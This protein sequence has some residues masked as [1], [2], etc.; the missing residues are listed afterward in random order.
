MASFGALERLQKFDW[1]IQR[2]HSLRTPIQNDKG[3][4]EL[5]KLQALQLLHKPDL[6]FQAN[7]H[8][9]EDGED[10]SNEIVD[11][12]IYEEDLEDEEMVEEDTGVDKDDSDENGKDQRSEDFTRFGERENQ[13]FI[14]DQQA[15]PKPASYFPFSHNRYDYHTHNNHQHGGKN[16]QNNGIN[17]FSTGL[18]PPLPFKEILPLLENSANK[19]RSLF[20]FISQKLFIYNFLSVIKY[21][22]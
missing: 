5:R 14:N 10:P 3:L 21:C 18:F 12:D 15:D 1:L 8:M 20:L 6:M 22:I 4:E 19:V 9:E 13:D 11:E 2:L 7:H 17:R 16:E